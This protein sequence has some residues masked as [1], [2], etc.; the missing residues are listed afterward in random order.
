[1]TP[2]AEGLRKA[3]K[4]FGTDEKALIAILS[5]PNP[6]EM[7][8]LRTTFERRFMKKLLQEIDKETSG[9]FQYGLQ[10]LVRGPLMQDVFV[11]NEGIKGMGTK[12]TFL[13]DV[14]LGRSNADM[15]AIKQAYQDTYKRSLEADLRGDLS[16]KTEQLFMMVTAA[17]RDEDSAPVI[18]QQIDA[19]V[20]EL[21]GATAG[22]IGKDSATVCAIF[23]NRNDAQL[24]AI[25]QAYEA[26]YGKQLEKVIASEFS[27]HMEEAL[28][29]QLARAVDRARSDA[30][31]LEDAMKG[32]GTKD[33][34]LVNRVVRAH[35]NRGHMQKVKAMYKH[36]YRKE[37][38]DRIKSETR[39]DY[40][41]LMVACCE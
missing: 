19:W 40:E 8:T 12:E 26:K 32:M 20:T 27:G 25:N 2:Q 11:L 15:H 28:L 14:L 37:L 36:V 30:V 41:R 1:M 5:K 39:G 29:L 24:R 3:M 38:I 13:N 4:G 23:C 35:W 22:R 17:R 31:Q 21:H 34:L 16:M 33:K 10:A 7:E 6:I 9:Y 18:A